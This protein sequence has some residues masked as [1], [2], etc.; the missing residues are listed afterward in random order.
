MTATDDRLHASDV[1]EFVETRGHEPW[2]I[3]RLR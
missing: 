1:E 3:E 2:S